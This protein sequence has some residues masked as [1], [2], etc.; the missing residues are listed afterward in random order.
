MRPWMRQRFANCNVPAVVMVGRADARAREPR[1][2]VLWVCRGTGGTG[3][4]APRKAVWS[5]Q[6]SRIFLL[7]RW[8]TR[9]QELSVVSGW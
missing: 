6:A 7:L 9:N 5:P 3:E 4:A 1:I 2:A 8:G